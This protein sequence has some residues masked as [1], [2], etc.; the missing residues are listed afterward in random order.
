MKT[1]D[2]IKDIITN[3]LGLKDL[4][5]YKAWMEQHT[6][7]VPFEKR[8]LVT[9]E[10]I[11]LLSPNNIHNGDFWRV[12]EEVF[13]VD[14]VAATMY[15]KLDSDKDLGSL[16]N[17][18]LARTGGML[19]FVDEWRHLHCPVLEIGA[20]YGNFKYYCMLNTA[21]KYLG[22]DVYPKSHGIHAALPNGTL[23]PYILNEK[24]KFQIVYS[25]NVFQH[26]S[27]E[28]RS[29]YFQDIFDLM[30]EHGLFIFNLTV[31]YHDPATCSDKARMS[32]DGRQYMCHYGQ[33]TEVPFYPELQQ[34]LQ[35]Y[36]NIEYETRRYSDYLFTFALSR[37]NPPKVE[38]TAE[39]KPTV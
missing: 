37:K 23:P 35:K 34:E 17:L 10:D 11:A 33:W 26:L 2:E 1:Y 31:H 4:A 25:S 14:C 20:G 21:F 9:P 36:F 6:V 32:T 8:K 28:Q 29:V 19:N 22:V 27:K 13:G 16:R 3:Q 18:S 15:G 38:A 30:T 24:G 5:S 12:V 7:M 39:V